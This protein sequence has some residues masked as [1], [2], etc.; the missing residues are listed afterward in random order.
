MGRIRSGEPGR[1]SLI[2]D[3]PLNSMEEEQFEK[4]K[5]TLRRPDIHREITSDIISMGML[6]PGDSFVMR[7]LEEGDGEADLL[8]IDFRAPGS[9]I[10][11]TDGDVFPLQIP[12]G[13]NLS[14]FSDIKMGASNTSLASF[15]FSYFPKSLI[16]E[17]FFWIENQGLIVEGPKV[18]RPVTEKGVLLDFKGRF[19]GAWLDNDVEGF[20][21]DYHVHPELSFRPSKPD[22]LSKM[23]GDRFMRPE[24]F[25]YEHM[26]P[27]LVFDRIGRG[28]MHA[29]SIF[30]PYDT[31]RR[32]EKIRD[33]Y[34]A[35]FIKARITG[36][37]LK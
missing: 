30:R 9:A 12:P 11:S 6:F 16:R 4:I 28:T 35:F 10:L 37:E 25:E 21:F 23:P 31:S 24:E 13:K 19:I 2:P 3:R 26:A 8:Q 27:Q 32:R 1:V 14:L 20:L 22:F 17:A 18:T 33:F 29:P 36:F 7:Q 5:E 15:L 34:N